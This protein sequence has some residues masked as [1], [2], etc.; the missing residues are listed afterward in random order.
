LV[1]GDVLT[2]A[3]INAVRRACPDLKVINGYG[4]TENTT[5]SICHQING[6]Y[7]N[8]IPIGRPISN[9]TAYIVDPNM[10][11]QPVG[12]VGEICVG[13]DGVAA[14]YL[15]NPELTLE[16]FRLDPFRHIEAFEKD[17]EMSMMYKTG[18][19]GKWLPDGTIEFI[20]RKDQQVK[21][22]GFRIELEEIENRLLKHPQIE[23]AVVMAREDHSDEGKYLCGYLVTKID[24]NPIE[25]KE[26][27]MAGLPDYMIPSYFVRLEEIPLTIN[28]KVDK[29]KLPKPDGNLQ[30]DH[31]MENPLGEVEEKL[32]IIWQ[33]ILDIKMVGR[34]HNFFDIGGHSLKAGKVA[35]EIQ[36]VFGTE[37]PIKEI[38]NRPTLMEMASYIKNI[39]GKTEVVAIKPTA[40]K[41]YYEL[42]SAQ[43]RLYVVS[44]F[45]REGVAY[46]VPA[47]MVVEGALDV[48]KTE[49]AFKEVIRRHDSLRT[50]FHLINEEPMQQIANELAFSM[51][52]EE[53]A[54]D[55]GLDEEEFILEK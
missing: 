42:S 50:S 2:P 13:G 40:E 14:G 10:H 37:Y 34:N 31:T 6:D 5:F 16:K 26:Y 4:P 53:V 35:S 38:F 3:H 47:V 21:I 44:Q 25:I 49:A 24:L 32:A 30:L 19:L 12:V 45:Q 8:N 46:N 11:L 54:M 41:E 52:Y 17:E 20:G 48:K 27:L 28:G 55:E 22:R 7:E 18:D 36:K 23:E 43:K 15:N 51:D 1:G 9:S 39:D 33:N 29:Q